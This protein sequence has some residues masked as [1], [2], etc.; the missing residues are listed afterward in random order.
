MPHKTPGVTFPPIQV[1]FTP[2][3]LLPAKTLAPTLFVPPTPIDIEFPTPKFSTDPAA[4]GLM[5]TE[6]IG[7]GTGVIN[8][9]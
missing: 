8:I 2:R 1:S 4:P 7:A 3:E 6:P 9:S 5:V